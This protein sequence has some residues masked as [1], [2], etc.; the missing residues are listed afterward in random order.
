MK[1]IS[2]GE[3]YTSEFELTDLFG[4]RQI[5]SDGIVFTMSQ[6]RKSNGLLYLDLCSGTYT[7]K[8][9]NSF[10]APEKSIV[11]LPYGS[12]YS[13]VNHVGHHVGP[14][15]YLIEFNM[16]AN[17]E[18]LT[19]SDAPFL[20]NTID[21]YF[22]KEHILKTVS[23]YEA[24]VRSPLAMRSS[25]YSVLS[26]L[27]HSSF[28]EYEKKY[29]SIAP[30]IKL[31]KELSDKSYS[32]QFLAEACNM[33]SA[34]FRRLFKEYSGKSPVEYRTELKINSAKS[35]LANSKITLSSLS[36]A[37]GFENAAYFCRVFKNKTGMTPGEYRKNQR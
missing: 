15:A 2:F 17:E 13:V 16:T 30:G 28:S 33:S 1:S 10:Y 26:A 22:I 7:D 11:M 27:G 18:K 19:F 20:I 3:L 6:P 14:N 24:P 32:I 9:G 36:E 21:Q 29:S 4:M 5:W 31:L 35:L 37:L 8:Y 12:C 25:V 23:A 34:C